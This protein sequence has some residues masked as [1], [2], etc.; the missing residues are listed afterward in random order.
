[1]FINKYYYTILYIRFYIIKLMTKEKHNFIL[2]IVLQLI[3]QFYLA[4]IILKSIENVFSIVFTIVEIKVIFFKISKEK[5]KHCISIEKANLS[6][7]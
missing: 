6:N 5:L 1:M 3:N 4:Y 7:R 2:F